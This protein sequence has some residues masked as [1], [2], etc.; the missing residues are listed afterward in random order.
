MIHASPLWDAD[1]NL[2]FRLFEHGKGS[3]PLQIIDDSE[4]E[5][6]VSR[7]QDL[8][9]TSKSIDQIKKYGTVDPDYIYMPKIESTPHQTIEVTRIL[10]K[11]GDLVG[12]G[13]DLIEVMDDKA[14]MII[15]ARKAGKVITVL[16]KPGDEV[17]END[18]LAVIEE[19]KNE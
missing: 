11:T 4:F 18:P 1:G 16:V 6:M 7:L 2:L 5:S 13:T 19:L 10:V 9:E 15:S 8:L 17:A 3:T 14:S 12:V